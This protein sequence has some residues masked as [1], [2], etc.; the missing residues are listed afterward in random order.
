VAKTI[1]ANRE[2]SGRA[3]LKH[4]SSLALFAELINRGHWSLIR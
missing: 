1:A 3:L 4:P 2:I